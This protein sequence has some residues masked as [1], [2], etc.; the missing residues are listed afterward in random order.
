[1]VE[2]IDLKAKVGDYANMTADVFAASYG[3]IDDTM[4]INSPTF[5]DSAKDFAPFYSNGEEGPSNDQHGVRM[6]NDIER[7][8][9]ALWFYDSAA[10]NPRYMT[11]GYVDS[12][13]VELT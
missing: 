4:N 12:D 11:I 9:Q 3:K 2:R 7:F 5:D 10:G 1:V 6:S 8:D 13:Y